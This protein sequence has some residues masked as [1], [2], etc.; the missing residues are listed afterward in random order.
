MYP[1][2]KT[3]ELKKTWSPMR[4]RKGKTYTVTNLAKKRKKYSSMSILVLNF[5]VGNYLGR[6]IFFSSCIQ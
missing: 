4:A 2:A 6:Q 1:N 3:Q 5:K